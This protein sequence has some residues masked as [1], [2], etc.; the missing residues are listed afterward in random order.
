MSRFN[1][2]THFNEFNT[3]TILVIGDVM[4][5]SYMW[6]SVA[7]ISPEAPVPIVSVNSRES[8]I[9]G[10]A[11]VALNIKELG[12]TPIICSVIGNDEKADE[13]ITLMSEFNLSAE[14]VIKDANRKTTTKTRVISNNQQLL[15]VDEEIESNICN[16]TEKL[17]S[18]KIIEIINDKKI[19]AIIFE[20]YDKGVITK[21]IISKI[22]KIANAKNIITTVDPKK[23]NFNF[24]KNVSLFK[25]NLKEITEGL[26]I[27]IDV[28]NKED[29]HNKMQFFHKDSNIKNMLVTLSEHGVFYS[30]LEKYYSV[31]AVVRDIADV[32][33]AGDTVISVATLCLASGMDGELTARISNIA[34]GLVCEKVGVVPVNKSQLLDECMALLTWVR[35]KPFV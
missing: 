29:L 2:N 18:D 8:R 24:Y 33:G 32:S 26:N 25:P 22:V 13:F 9:G 14:G 17:F 34:G 12:A 20:D 4:I 27:D 5:D 23:R 3:K 7:R 16:K 10:A 28:Q 1:L 31:P 35:Y 30:D 21:N 15:R 6:G 11:N 19:D